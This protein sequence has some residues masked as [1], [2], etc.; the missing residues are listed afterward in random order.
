M[1][2][3]ARQMVEEHRLGPWGKIVK[4]DGPVE[5]TR[6]VWHSRFI[7]RIDKIL[8]VEFHLKSP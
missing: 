6:T 8:K 5:M 7:D 4:S 1:A 2:D 3:A